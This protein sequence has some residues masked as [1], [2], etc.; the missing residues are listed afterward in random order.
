MLESCIISIKSKK[1][2][3]F[4]ISDNKQKIIMKNY[5]GKIEIDEKH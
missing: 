4:H 1:T 3:I 5:A 2:G